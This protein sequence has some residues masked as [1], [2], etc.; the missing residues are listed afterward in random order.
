MY[1]WMLFSDN[2]V[3]AWGENYSLASDF[4]GM[5]KEHPPSVFIQNLDD[6]TAP[7]QGTLAYAQKLLAIKVQCIAYRHDRCIPHTAGCLL[8][9]CASPPHNLPLSHNGGTKSKPISLSG[10]FSL[11][12]SRSRKH[13]HTRARAR[14][15]ERT[16]PSLSLSP[17]L[18]LA[19]SLSVALSRPIYADKQLQRLQTLHSDTTSQ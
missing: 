5:S 17:S 2:K 8:S 19:H 18:S 16:P 3:P 7:P 9:C 10:F 13:T 6:G 12:E 14:K 4:D 1:P 15:R 11:S